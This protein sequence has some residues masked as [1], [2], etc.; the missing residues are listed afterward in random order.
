MFA[1]VEPERCLKTAEALFAGGIHML[2]ITFNV[3]EPEKDENVADCIAAIKEY[4]G[5]NVDH[6]VRD[7]DVWG[8]TLW[9]R[10]PLGEFPR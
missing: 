9:K 4:F 10:A 7:G 6:M 3:K 8:S 5:V 2:E 1:G